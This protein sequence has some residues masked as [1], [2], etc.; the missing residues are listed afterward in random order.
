[1]SKI[2]TYILIGI[3]VLI[4]IIFGIPMIIGLFFT[5]NP[6]GAFQQGQ[7]IAEWEEVFRVGEE[8][9][10]ANSIICVVLLSSLIK[11]NSLALFGLGR[12]RLQTFFETMVEIPVHHCLLRK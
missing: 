6:S 2:L 10:P 7:C 8:P 11:K 1:M 12:Q 9:T 3:I 4:V 5:V